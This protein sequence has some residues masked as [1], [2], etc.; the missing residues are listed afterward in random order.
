MVFARGKNPRI[1]KEP[2]LSVFVKSPTKCLARHAQASVR[3]WKQLVE[4]IAF[5][6]DQTH[7]DALVEEI[8]GAASL[9]G[10]HRQ[11]S[12]EV[13]PVWRYFRIAAEAAHRDRKVKWDRRTR[14]NMGSR[15]PRRPNRRRYWALL[16]QL[17]KRN[18]RA[19]ALT[20]CTHGFRLRP[21]G[22]T[23]RAGATRIPTSPW[24]RTFPN[25][26]TAAC[27][28]RDFEFASCIWD[29]YPRVAWRVI[30]LVV[31]GRTLKEERNLISVGTVASP[32]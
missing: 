11:R 31:A 10:R 5:I 24:R 18:F 19:I 22:R 17:S 15:R 27:A 28:N 4:R 13:L 7:S 26:L 30:G 16:E 32:R 20:L 25:P 1:P 3:G 21:D 6:H 9:R 8:H 12:S 14:K 2:Q 29:N 23:V